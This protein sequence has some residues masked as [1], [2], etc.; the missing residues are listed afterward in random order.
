M[1]AKPGQIMR[2]AEVVTVGRRVYAVGLFW[3]PHKGRS[4]RKDALTLAKNQG[5]EWICMHAT[6]SMLSAGMA[7]LVV[8]SSR[9]AHSLAATLA[10]KLGAS[11]IAAFQVGPDRYVMAAA[12]NGAITPGTDRVGTCAEIQAAF[13]AQTS[14]AGDGENAWAR[15]IAPAEWRGANEVVGLE[16]LLTG[17]R[18]PR[19]ATLRPTTFRLTRRQVL[20]ASVVG[21]ALIGGTV[22]TIKLKTHRA[23]AERQ[24]RIAAAQAEAE[25]LRTVELNRRIVAGPWK[26]IPPAAAVVE[27]CDIG[28]HVIPIEIRGWLFSTSTC[29]PESM[30]AIYRR[31]GAATV[32]IFAEATA[33]QFGKPALMENGEAAAISFN[34][35]L[36]P[37]EEPALAPISDQAMKLVST[38]QRH[39]I[40][41]TL[42]ELRKG[43]VGDSVNGEEQVAAWHAHDWKI[44]TGVPPA[45]L[46]AGLELP[47]LRVSTITTTLAEAESELRWVIEGTIYG[48]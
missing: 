43:G 6:P 7:S 1:R 15:A 20:I 8:G 5:F 17:H 24:A 39:G 41:M 29:T 31:T 33:A 25:A 42:G 22:T 14:A 12:R 28:M 19:A 36:K 45:A 48:K 34:S 9:R 4:A 10:S 44:E 11:W 2:P 35:T 27:T 40:G 30:V 38:M 26:D 18:P 32:D 13:E 3:Q 47:G 23:E 46:F 21:L 16:A 37:V